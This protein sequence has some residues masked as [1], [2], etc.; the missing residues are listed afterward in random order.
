LYIYISTQNTS[1]VSAPQL[2]RFCI[3]D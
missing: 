3:M 2:S 1:L